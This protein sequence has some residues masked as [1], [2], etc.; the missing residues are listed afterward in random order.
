MLIFNNLV[1]NKNSNRYKPFLVNL[2]TGRRQLLNS[3]EISLI[4]NM[5]KTFDK[6]SKEEMDLFNELIMK[7]Q[8]FT[9][10][11]REEIE[12][13]L[14]NSGYFAKKNIFAEDYRFSI[15][16]T[17]ACNMSCSF[18]YANGRSKDTESMTKDK[19]DAIYN[20]YTKYADDREK[21]K[22]TPFIRITGGEPLLN[23]ETVNIINYIAE[24]WEKSKLILFTNGVNLL[25][26][27]DNIPLDRCEEVHISLDGTEEVHMN[28][29]Y[30]HSHPTPD[31]YKNIIIG[32][33]KLISN[34]VNVKIKTT[35]GKDNYLSMKEL[36]KYLVDND[37][38]N[39]TYCE[40]LMG[41]TLDYHN[42][43]DISEKVND[44]FL[45]KKMENY[46]S[47]YNYFPSTF[48]SNSTLLSIITR[49][50]NEPYLPKCNRCRNGRL[51]NYFFSCNGNVYHCDCIEEND[52]IVGTF[53]PEIKLNEN[54]VQE[55]FNRNI[56]NN[57]QCR[58]CP[59][60]FV[61]LGGC[62][63]AARTKK[64]EMAC[65]IYGDDEILDNL[66]FNYDWIDAKNLIG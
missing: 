25:K 37:I 39:S 36:K 4:K 42:P 27:Y 3:Y 34:K 6:Y 58:K 14:I 59:Y 54:I 41:V 65:G 10:D 16:I 63:L 60:K 20:F 9:D 29:R 7:K 21:I 51:A 8:F 52:G 1:I 61:C 13:T 11:M 64:Q 66:E 18:C 38:L 35:L 40:H 12:T 57:D 5:N 47:D 32:I 23:D 28:H 33:K 50:K 48:P 53:Y 17:R 44:K 22:D 30:S 56:L 31:V 24:R 62:P 26:Y 19:V 55:L 15:E 46:L 49:P 43:L 2:V 45:I